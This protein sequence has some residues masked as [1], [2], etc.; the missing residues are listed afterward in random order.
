MLKFLMFLHSLTH[1]HRILAKD[2]ATLYFCGLRGPWGKV[3]IHYQP[4]Q[5]IEPFPITLDQAVKV[6]KGE[7]L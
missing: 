7:P 6:I 4:N 3:R 1:K 2:D 5:H